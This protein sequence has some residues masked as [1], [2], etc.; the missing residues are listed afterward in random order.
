[1]NE[2]SLTNVNLSQK[3]LSDNDLNPNSTS[4]HEGKSLSNVTFVTNMNNNF[5]KNFVSIH[6]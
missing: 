5:G 2:K 1:M 4:V 3:L 6:E